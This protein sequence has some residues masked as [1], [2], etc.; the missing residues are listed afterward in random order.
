MNNQV[1]SR[2][3]ARS[4]ARRRSGGLRVAHTLGLVALG[5]VGVVVA[6]SVLSFIAGILWGIVKVVV[7]VGVVGGVLW[8]LLRRGRR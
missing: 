2:R 1:D 8:L 3:D 5:V 4:P 7:V 6:F